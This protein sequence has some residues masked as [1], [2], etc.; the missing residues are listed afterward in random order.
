MASVAR[1]PEKHSSDCNR[2]RLMSAFPSPMGQPQ[3]CPSGL[4]PVGSEPSSIF[5][6][7]SQFKHIEKNFKMLKHEVSHYCM[8]RMKQNNG[9][10]LLWAPVFNLCCNTVVAQLVVSLFRTVP[11]LSKDK[12]VVRAVS[13]P[14]IMQVP[15]QKEKTV[16][17]SA[18]FIAKL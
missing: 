18:E 1:R 3:L 8:V 9:Q 14:K 6:E 15:F 13:S 16:V 5:C 17:Y 4:A 2:G 12:S 7:I 10:D 11:D